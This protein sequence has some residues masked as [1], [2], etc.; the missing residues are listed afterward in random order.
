VRDKP[1]IPG[2]T[3]NLFVFTE[4]HRFN[5]TLKTGNRAEVDY[6]VN[7]VPP[8]SH[9]DAASGAVHELLLNRTATYDGFQLRAVSVLPPTSRADPRGASVIRFELRSNKKIYAFQPG[10]IGVKQGGQFLT[11]ESLYFDSMEIRPNA[12]AITGKLV[13]LNQ[14]RTSNLNL[15][16]VF[17]VPGKSK[18]E[19]PH[20]LSVNLSPK[21]SSKG[22]PHGPF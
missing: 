9:Q 18:K 15:E 12:Q 14:D 3:S 16:L 5:C 13:I 7:I 4:F 8:E 10:S 20:A 17:A 11:I 6:I 22:V 19:K 2:A 1:I 21:L